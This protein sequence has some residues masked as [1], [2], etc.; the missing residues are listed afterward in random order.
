MKKR[1]KKNCIRKFILENLKG[2]TDKEA[3]KIIKETCKD[4]AE[5]PSM[6]DK[7]FN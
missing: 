1:V 7:L 6:L 2:Q 5:N 3:I 4:K